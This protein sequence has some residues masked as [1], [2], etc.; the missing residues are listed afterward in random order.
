MVGSIIQKRFLS[1]FADVVRDIYMGGCTAE[2]DVLRLG[3]SQS[4]RE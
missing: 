1:P 3:G 4:W 2:A